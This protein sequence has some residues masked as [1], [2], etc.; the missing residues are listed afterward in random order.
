LKSKKHLTAMLAFEA[1][2]Q[3]FLAPQQDQRRDQP[4][5][6]C[7]VTNFGS[8]PTISSRTVKKV[9]RM[10]RVKVG[11][12]ERI[13]VAFGCSMEAVSR[14]CKDLR[15]RH[16]PGQWTRRMIDLANTPCGRKSTKHP[17]G[18]S[19]HMALQ[20][21][22]DAGS[23]HFA[24]ARCQFLSDVAKVRDVSSGAPLSEVPHDDVVH[25]MSF[26]CTQLMRQDS[27]MRKL[28]Q[29]NNKRDR[30]G[31]AVKE[32]SRERGG[33]AELEEGESPQ[34]AATRR[35]LAQLE[36]GASPHETA[37]CDPP[38]E[39]A[40]LEDGDLPHEAAAREDGELPPETAAREDGAL[41][42]DT[43]SNTAACGPPQEAAACKDG[44]LPHEAAALE[45]GELPHEAAAPEG[46]AAPQETATCDPPQEAAACEGGELFGGRAAVILPAAGCTVLVDAMNVMGG[47]TSHTSVARLAAL[48]ASFNGPS[49]CGGHPHALAF[50][51][52]QIYRGY[53]HRNFAQ[54]DRD[55]WL[56]VV[57]GPPGADD[58][59]LI[60]YSA[61]YAVPIIT[62][63]QF[64]DH[65]H[66]AQHNTRLVTDVLLVAADRITHTY[67]GALWELSTDLGCEPVLRDARH[68]G[69]YQT[70]PDR[71]RSH[72]RVLGRLPL[73]SGEGLEF[74]PWEQW[75]ADRRK[76]AADRY[77]RCGAAELQRW[78]YQMRWG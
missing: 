52:R 23:P 16:G 68:A 51:P 76:K 40:A 9:C 30:D 39:A 21:A 63:D 29:R 31:T 69:R 60:A 42:Y 14:L 6:P 7:S 45:D 53:C 13:A 5:Q 61:T 8:I 1:V 18:K 22:V 43:F 33:T 66:A 20:E 57:D 27:M 56:F 44:E 28:A 75:Q 73:L 11:K 72:R 67:S 47:G 37:A 38:H 65:I 55:G 19:L 54:M 4:P 41:P 3:G 35:V 36:D 32:D 77:A 17:R 25:A 15:G 12:K 58:A 71:S 64:V 78:V 49:G 46:G 10:K 24:A 74:P 2:L 50:L 70:D 26:V 34:K 59:A 48:L 62:N